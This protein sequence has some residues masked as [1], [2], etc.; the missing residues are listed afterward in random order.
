MIGRSAVRMTAST[1]PEWVF[2]CG[3]AVGQRL[4]ST[5]LR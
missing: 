2:L 1:V 4:L 5:A 3:E